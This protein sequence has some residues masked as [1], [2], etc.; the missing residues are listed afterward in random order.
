M[1]V[2]VCEGISK[3]KGKREFVKNFSYN[4]LD[5]QVY[6][7]IGKNDWSQDELLNLI[8]CKNKPTEGCVYLDGEPLYN[9]N[10]MNERLCYIPRN[11]TFPKWL[12]IIDIFQLFKLCYPKWD[13]AYAYELTTHFQI[14]LKETYGHLNESRKSLLIGILG[15]ASM[16][17]ITVFDNPIDKVDLKDRY[18]YFQFLYRHHERY[19]RTFIISTSFIDEIDYIVDK[20]L[21]ID[22]GR[23]FAQ[24][25]IDEIK[26][27]FRYLS[28]KTEVLKSLISG[29]KVIGVEE[30]GKTLTVCIRQKL[31]K[32]DTRKYQKYLIK[33]SEVPIQNIFIYLMNLRV[34][35][36]KI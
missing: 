5:N 14:S 25:T 4:F 30:R 6:A 32:D 27:S 11:T 12:R 15:L 13:N 1:S 10:E 7:L 36:E 21:F 18:D 2:L 31:S 35:K 8:C 26:D 20:I 23:L 28:G 17:N 29:V 34:I 33:I 19:P 24:F 22:K 3:V 9:N 16:A